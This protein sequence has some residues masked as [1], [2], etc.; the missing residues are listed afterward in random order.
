MAGYSA[1]M[2]EPSTDPDLVLLERGWLS[3]NNVL[4]RSETHA[5][6]IDS[7]H[8]RHVEQTL[9]LVQ[10]GLAGLPLHGLVNTHLHSDHCGGNARL[11]AVHALQVAVP[12]GH[13]QSA[14]TWDV[15]ALGYRPTGQ[16]C[17]RFQVDAVVQ[18]GAVVVCGRWRFEALAA[19]G[20]DPHA[21]IFFDAASGTLISGDALWQDGFGV[22]F[23]ELDGEAGF[24]DVA[25]TLDLIERLPVH[26]VVPGHGAPFADVAGALQR[27]RQ[28]L[29]GLRRDP[30]RHARHGA[31]V[32]IKYHLMELGTQPLPELKAW[33][34]ATPLLG[35]CLRRTGQTGE[36]LQFGLHLLDELLASGAL[37]HADGV[38]QD[39]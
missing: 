31:K 39:V 14:R 15:D 12:P 28:R 32:L 11:Q 24:D 10:H 8:A 35:S 21:L 34:A 22:V 36:P 38:V 6:L 20:H 7:G 37:M 3:S 13:A 2:H 5:L 1:V 33:L 16:M 18:P 19:P 9:A 27:A 26:H 29:A 23:P 17:P 4:L 30:A 25:S